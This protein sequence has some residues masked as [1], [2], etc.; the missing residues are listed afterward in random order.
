MEQLLTINSI[1][2]FIAGFGSGLCV[3]VLLGVY[4]GIHYRNTQDPVVWAN[5]FGGIVAMLWAGLHTYAIFSGDIQI[6]FIFDVVGGLA[7]GQTL[8]IDLVAAIQ[9]IRK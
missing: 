1:A 5:L 3:G 8:G 2:P 4:F 7:M 9:K 6:P